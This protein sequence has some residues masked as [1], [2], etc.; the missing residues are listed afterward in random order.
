[1]N[2]VDAVQLSFGDGKIILYYPDGP[3][4]FTVV[5]ISGRWDVSVREEGDMIAN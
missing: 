3:N 4:I 2:F 5:L 1:M